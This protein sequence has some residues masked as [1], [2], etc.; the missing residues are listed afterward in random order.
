MNNKPWVRVFCVIVI[1]AIGLC[2]L[3]CKKEEGPASPGGGS[4]G[5][6]AFNFTTPNQSLNVPFAGSP[7]QAKL[8]GGILPYT[9]T[10]APD[11]TIATVTVRSDTITVT[12][13]APGSTSVTFSDSSPGMG[14]RPQQVVVIAI[15]VAV[16]P[17]FTVTI[18]PGTTPQYSWTTGGAYIV[19]VERT[20]NLGT[21]VWGIMCQGTSTTCITSPVTHGTT[22]AGTTLQASTEMTLTQGVRYRINVYLGPG[23]NGGY[24]EFTP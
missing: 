8:T 23:G 19:Y 4:D 20:S 3:S 7:V 10:V 18:G 12:P 17:S 21:S 13:R 6:T 1:G 2:E 22:P 16:P 5:I 14:E 24:T 9:I 15:V 11:T